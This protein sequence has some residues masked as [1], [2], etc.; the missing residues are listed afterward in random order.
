MKLTPVR[1]DDEIVT[2]GYIPHDTNARLDCLIARSEEAPF[3]GIERRE[4]S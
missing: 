1:L 4:P 2:A 3:I